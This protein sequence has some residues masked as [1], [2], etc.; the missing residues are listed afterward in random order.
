MTAYLIL[1]KFFYIPQNKSEIKTCIET[2]H[3]VLN[4]S[5]LESK[6]LEISV[7]PDIYSFRTNH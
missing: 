2:I 6:Y 5:A 4:Y 3:S 1:L 7:Q